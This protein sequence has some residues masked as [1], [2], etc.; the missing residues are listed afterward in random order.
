M[1]LLL[2]MIESESSI[3]S[4]VPEYVEFETSEPS[5]IF[6]TIDG[7]VPDEADLIAVG[8]LYMP[9]HGRAFTLKVIAVSG[10]ESSD[11]LEEDYSTDSS[12]LTRTR[13]TGDEGIVV[14]HSDGIYV[15]H[16][17][18]DF[19]GQD[20]QKTSIDFLDLHIVADT[21]NKKGESLA[22]KTLRTDTTYSFIN[23]LD[24]S[25]G[26]GMV[27]VSSI[28]DANFYPDAK[29]INMDGSTRELLESQ[30]ERVI[31]RPNG[32]LSPTS[33]FYNDH[34]PE[35]SLVSGSFIRSMYNPITNKMVFYYRESRE[36]R[37][38]KSTQNV[39]AT[40]IRSFAGGNSFVFKWVEDRSVSKIY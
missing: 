9:T 17:S 13:N 25:L 18:F 2:T 32:T 3:I 33:N 20:A 10:Q 37:W 5:T 30:T 29:V 6:Y 21:T 12:D 38:I 19:E 36:N 16:R 14:L 23:L 4:G 22:N 26:A 35:R 40:A 8:R 28:N 31:N 15:D 1:A 11:I 39:E 24:R 7:S 27:H 34:L